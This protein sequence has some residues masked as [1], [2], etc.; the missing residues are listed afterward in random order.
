M[1]TC[2]SLVFVVMLFMLFI[3]S[4]TLDDTRGADGAGFLSRPVVIR[5]LHLLISSVG[6]PGILMVIAVILS[7]QKMRYNFSKDYC[8]KFIG[9]FAFITEYP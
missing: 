8:N 1:M 2:I 3:S 7:S 6:V 9:S 4:R 5:V